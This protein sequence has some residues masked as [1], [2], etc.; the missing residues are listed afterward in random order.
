MKTKVYSEVSQPSNKCNVTNT[1]F[2]TISRISTRGPHSG[3]SDE[4]DHF[5]TSTGSSRHGDLATKP[6]PPS[7]SNRARLRMPRVAH[8]S[9]HVVLG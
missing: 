8:S 3:L 4:D 1:S 7:R 5:N 6:M 2:L 9:W